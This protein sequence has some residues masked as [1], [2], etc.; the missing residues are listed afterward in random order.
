MEAEQLQSAL[1]SL[2][3]VQGEPIG[4][5]RLALVLEVSEEEVTQ[6]LKHMTKEYAQPKRGLS[7]IR[8][9]DLV[10]LVTRSEN[11]VYMEKFAKSSAQ[12]S[13]SKAALEVLSVIAYRGPIARSEIEAIRGVN[14]SVT[15]RNLLMREL[16]ERKGNPDDARGYI[17]DISFRFLRELGLKEV[18]E[19]PEYEALSRDERLE[20]VLAPESKKDNSEIQQ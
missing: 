19:L 2:L 20:M 8:K 4:I 11:A 1:E 15:I 6:A 3:F 5:G 14:C 7:L 16:I 9:Q 10:Q 12:E 18:S 13:L 17:Y